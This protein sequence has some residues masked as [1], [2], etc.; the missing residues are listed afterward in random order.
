MPTTK[1]TLSRFAE[2]IPVNRMS[3][4][5]QQRHL[6][7]HTIPRASADRG[8]VPTLAWS[9]RSAQELVD[10]QCLRIPVLSTK[11]A[12][13]VPEAFDGPAHLVQI[14]F[15]LLAGKGWLHIGLAD[16]GRN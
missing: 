3:L 15:D 16:R 10:T 9:S 12:A 11:G 8:Q 1:A 6:S 2:S 14:E 13:V 4:H 5:G 7:L